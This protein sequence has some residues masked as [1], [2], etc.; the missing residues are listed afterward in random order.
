M[1]STSDRS[2]ISSRVRS[3]MV[4]GLETIHAE[5]TS[6]GSSGLSSSSW[7]SRKSAGPGFPMYVSVFDDAVHPKGSRITASR[8]SRRRARLESRGG[9][10]ENRDPRT[11]HR[12]HDAVS[13]CVST[14]SGHYR[15]NRHKTIRRN[16]DERWVDANH[17]RT[18]LA[19]NRSDRSRTV[20]QSHSPC[21]LRN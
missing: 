5:S 17:S 11:I 1:A 19:R 6:A 2:Q 7:L 13:P 21:L 14:L 20:G 8:K 16:G 3:D 15:Q 4:R 18:V 12:I 9:E 10:C